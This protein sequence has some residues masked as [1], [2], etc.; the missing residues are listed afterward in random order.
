MR[1]G[2]HLGE[3]QWSY[4]SYLSVESRASSS[5]SVVVGIVAAAVHSMPMEEGGGGNQWV[6][7]L[8]GL[9]LEAVE[10]WTGRERIEP[11]FL[12]E[13]DRGEYWMNCY[14]S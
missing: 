2:E 14:H 11:I 1:G 9:L 6:D 13:D 4:W 10:G 5:S 7:S 12:G 8:M 3:T